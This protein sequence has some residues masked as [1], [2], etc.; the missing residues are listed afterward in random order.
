MRKTYFLI[1]LILVV[2]LLNL[3]SKEGFTQALPN[4]TIQGVITNSQGQPFPALVLYLVHP[5]LGRS[6]P[7][8]TNQFGQYTFFNL[9]INQIYYLEIYWGKRLI[10]RQQCPPLMS[11]ILLLNPIRLN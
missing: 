6:F 7:A 5:Q 11:P 1:I 3:I 9:P 8:Y 2:C 4:G 10:Y